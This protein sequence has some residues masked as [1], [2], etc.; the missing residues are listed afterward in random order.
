MYYHFSHLFMS[1]PQSVCL[2]VHVCICLCVHPSARPSV[3]LSV[4]LAVYLSAFLSVCVFVC[5]FIY[6]PQPRN[7]TSNTP[8]SRTL[9]L[10]T[11]RFF[12]SSASRFRVL[13]GRTG[14]LYTGR[15]PCILPGLLLLRVDA[16]E[17][18]LQSVGLLCWK[19][20]SWNS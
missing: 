8:N 18:C 14:E 4:C 5:L 3:H 12:V 15:I 6:H 11:P 19:A 13:R 2:F 7:P 9:K 17:T 16:S 1:I 10:Q 20:E